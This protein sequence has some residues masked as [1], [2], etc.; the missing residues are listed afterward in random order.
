MT[1]LLTGGRGKTASHIASLLQAAK[2]PFIVASRS[3]NPS[4]SSPYY[5]NSFDWLDEKTYGDALTPKESM[6]PIS[7]VWLVPPPIFDL[8]PPMIKFVDFASRRGVKRFVLLSAS[9]IEKGGPAMGQVHEHLA[10]LGGI[11][12]AVLRPTWFMENF[13]YPQELQRLAIKNEN[14]IY[15]A[16]GDGK[17][18]FVSVADIARVAFRTLTDEKSH[19]TDYVLLGPELMTYDQVAETLSTVL[20]RTITHVKLTEHELAKRLENGGMPA[21]DAKMLAGMDT[22]I[23]DGVED[24][25]NKVVKHVTGADPRTF[26]DFATQQKATWG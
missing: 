23:S 5:Q 12:Y 17:L 7:T 2:V 8:A 19:N 10:S 15:S 3:S 6:Q 18:P 25:L 13:S 1:I 22:S 9:T 24:R 4:S 26:L 21:E 16:A 11:E 20:G 14:K